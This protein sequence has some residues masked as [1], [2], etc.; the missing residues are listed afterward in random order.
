MKENQDDLQEISTTEEDKILLANQIADLEEQINALTSFPPI[1]PM[2]G[3]CV[4][5]NFYATEEAVELLNK[6][7]DMVVENYGFKRFLATA[8]I[9]EECIKRLG[10]TQDGEQK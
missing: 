9:L 7:V 10:I 1:K 5:A 3:E 8:F 4:K 6:A 2:R